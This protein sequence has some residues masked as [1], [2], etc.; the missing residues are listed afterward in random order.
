MRHKMLLRDTTLSSLCTF[1]RRMWFL[2]CRF[3][4]VTASTVIELAVARE[5]ESDPHHHEPRAVTSPTMKREGS[6]ANLHS[7]HELDFE[8]SLS[9]SEWV[10]MLRKSTTF[11]REVD[12]VMSHIKES[13]VQADAVKLVYI[14]VRI[15]RFSEVNLDEQTFHVKLFVRVW[16]Q[17]SNADPDEFCV[18]FPFLSPFGKK[19]QCKCVVS[20]RRT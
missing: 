18:S 8:E 13:V 6:K 1:Q 11:E 20:A 12:L 7:G 10:E 9:R 17:R 19:V 4:L 15:L 14:R 3:D 5:L 2:W 16:W